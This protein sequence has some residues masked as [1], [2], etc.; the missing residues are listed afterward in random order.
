MDQTQQ[1]ECS[2]AK[3]LCGICNKILVTNLHTIFQTQARTA[4]NPVFWNPNENDDILDKVPII[5]F[6]KTLHNTMVVHTYARQ[7]RRTML[8]SLALLEK[9]LQCQHQDR[10]STLIRI[11][12]SPD[13]NLS[14]LL[15]VK[16]ALRLGKFI[17]LI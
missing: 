4:Y 8:F 1:D 16:F 10:V 13:L 14:D 5:Q 7:Y 6:I 17:P 12:M 9:G 2:S 15:L 11:R 3:I